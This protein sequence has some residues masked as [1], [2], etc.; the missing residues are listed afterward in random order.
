MKHIQKPLFQK[1]CIV[2]VGLMGGSLGLAIKRK[3]LARIVIGVSRH[4]STILKAFS[5][6]ALDM[7]T[8]DLVDGVREADLVILCAPV[9][10]I[11]RQMRLIAPH[12]KKGATVIDIGSSKVLIEK[13]AKKY[14]RKNIFIG[15][16]P[17]AGSENSGVENASADMFQDA[18]C[19]LTKPNAKISQFWKSLGALPIVMDAKKH[20]T[21]VAK[22]SHLPHLLAFSLFQ[23]FA[24]PKFPLN[25]SLKGLARIAGSNPDMWADIFLTNRESVLQALN[26]FEKNF[27]QVKK[28]LSQKNTPALK[29]LIANANKHSV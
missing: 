25:P 19:F 20:D 18:V 21:W 1:I 29:K 8:L 27:S 3:K 10:A 16:H 2:G 9:S 22:A 23:N 28:A 5:K 14:F 26:I 15:C 12:L 4:K 6:K 7:A 11:A 24:K 13:E 17:M